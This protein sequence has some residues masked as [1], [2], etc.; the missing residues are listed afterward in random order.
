MAQGGIRVC[1]RYNNNTTPEIVG[2]GGYFEYRLP[3]TV[4]QIPNTVYRIQNTVLS[5]RHTVLRIPYTV[6]ICGT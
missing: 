2:R 1:E 6:Y 4:Y 5:V 3:N